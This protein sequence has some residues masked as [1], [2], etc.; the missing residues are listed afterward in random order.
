M[1]HILLVILKIIG[2]LLLVILGILLFLVLTALC[3][4]VRYQVQGSWHSQLSLSAN[5]SWFLHIISVRVLYTKDGLK[6]VF[7]IFGFKLF[8]KRFEDAAEDV[9]EGTEKILEE[10]GKDLIDE[11]EKDEADFRKSAVERGKETK[12]GVSPKE[13]REPDREKREESKILL[14]PRRVIMK[15]RSLWEKIRFSFTHMCDKLKG[16]NELIQDKKKWLEDEKNQAS[17][18][19]LF[20]Q[21]KRLIAHMWPLKGQGSVTFG[22]DDPYT[23]GQVLSAVSLIYPLYHKQLA[24]HPVFDA[25]I[26]DAEGSFKGR[27]RLAAVAWLAIQIF[28]DRHTRRMIRS[29]IK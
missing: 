23:T 14:L 7:R 5:A 28:L 10:E 11:L 1:I 25:K 27:I 21:A 29:F 20:R 22:F 16:M 17:L 19:L 4:P 15:I 24:I 3:V 18:K 2:I 26:L 8:K 13:C 6:A 12:D 9:I